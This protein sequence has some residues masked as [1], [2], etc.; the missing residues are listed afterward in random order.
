MKWR[1]PVVDKKMRHPEQTGGAIPAK[2]QE[3]AFTQL[4][5]IVASW[6]FWLA[7]KA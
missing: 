1:D 6:P 5:S 3:L 2:I 7:T 4:V